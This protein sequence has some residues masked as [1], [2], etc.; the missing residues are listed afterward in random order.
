MR[1]PGWIP[2]LLVAIAVTASA[3]SARGQGADVTVELEQFGV[4]SV[5]RPA[6]FTGVRVSLTSN[7]EEQAVPVW[8]QWE[9]P[10]ADGDLAEYGRSITLNQGTPRAL[11]L[12]APLPPELAATNVWSVRVFEEREGRRRRELG[13]LRIT[14]QGPGVDISSA[15]IGVVGRSRMGLD[16]YGAIAPRSQQPAAWHEPTRVVFGIRPLE[17]PDRWEGLRPFEALVW[18]DGDPAELREET[19]GALVEYVRRGGH[20]VVCLPEAGNPWGLGDPGRIE[21]EIESLLP[22]AA[23]AR[24]EGVTVPTLLPVLGKSR[25]VGPGGDFEVGLRVF[26]RIGGSGLAEPWEPLVALADG[27]IVVIQRTVGFGRLTLAG[28]D[29]ASQQ[30]NRAPLDNGTLGLPQGDAF[31]NRVLGRRQDTPTQGELRALETAELLAGDSVFTNENGLGSGRLVAEAISMSRAAGIGLL[32]AIV[33]FIAYWLVA[34]PLGFYMI[35]K[36]LK[37]VRHA[38][39]AFAASAALFTALAWGVVSVIPQTD[40][41]VKHLTVLD[42]VARLPGELRP[43]D[44]QLQRAVSWMSVYLSD[45]RNTPVEVGGGDRRR[46][47]L[48]SRTLPGLNVQTFPNV[49]RYQV[50]LSRNPAA[51]A[52]PGRSTSTQLYAHWMGGVDPD[53]WGGLIRMDPDEPVTVAAGG[54]GARASLR[55]VLQHGLP[56]PLRH[57]TIIWNRGNRNTP[58]H[59]AIDSQN[60]E[61]LPWVPVLQSGQ[62]LNTGHLW[63]LAQPWEPGATLDLGGDTFAATGGTNLQA[64]IDKRYVEPFRTRD[65]TSI[66]GAGPLTEDARRNYLEMLSL[67][68]QLTPPTYLKS[69]PDENMPPTVRFYRQL[70]RELDLSPWFNRPCLIVLGFLE[71][72]PLPMPF[73]VD[74]A[75][76]ESSGLTVVR[77]ICPLPVEDDVVFPAASGDADERAAGEPG[78]DRPRRRG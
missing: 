58:R 71:D 5:Y 21:P 31:W 16:D 30:L 22:G 18:T 34:G 78:A 66:G 41:A 53:D 39:V 69:K 45:Y 70:G 42:H 76:P 36:P 62:M 55:G 40:V 12:Y 14:P 33:L 61:E 24:D 29:V 17:L 56:G 25:A 28:I 54:Q 8:V 11:W 23:P 68:N 57:V 59:Y 77:W 1:R 38:W 49:D 46:D 43:E 64:N 26:G 63:R 3:R 35:L 74:D 20:L 9:V 48:A 47:L 52:L 7:L 4:G 13:G 65:L 60:D 73:R 15:L 27:R 2:L 75:A 37:Q 72:V 50:D 10:N 44:P 67:F 19:A 6:E 32:L 51:F